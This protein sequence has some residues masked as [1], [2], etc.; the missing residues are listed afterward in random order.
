MRA[1]REK[2]GEDRRLVKAECRDGETVAAVTLSIVQCTPKNV[3][4]H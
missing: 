4:S 3:R 1:I 2:R